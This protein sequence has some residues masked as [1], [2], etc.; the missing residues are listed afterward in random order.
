MQLVGLPYQMAL[1]PPCKRMYPLGYY[2][3]GEPAPKIFYAIPF[4]TRAAA[5]TAG[6]YMG[7]ATILP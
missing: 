4:N 3:P 2:R 5:A 6:F 7:A 1:D